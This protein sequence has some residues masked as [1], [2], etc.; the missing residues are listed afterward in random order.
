M[1][2]CMIKL[3]LSWRTYKIQVLKI[4]LLNYSAFVS[5]THLL[6]PY[7]VMSNLYCPTVAE[8]GNLIQIFVVDQSIYRNLTG[9][10]SRFMKTNLNVKSC[11]HTGDCECVYL[12]DGIP[13]SLKPCRLASMMLG[14]NMFSNEDFLVLSGLCRCF[15]IV[16]DNTKLTFAIDNYKSIL[17]SDMYNQ[18]CSVID[19]ELRNGRVT[20]L[21]KPAACIHAL[22]AVVRPN[23]KLTSP[24]C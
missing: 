12:L 17:D 16:D 6:I 20:C 5:L 9:S 18:M 3:L 2:T 4:I 1:I 24:V 15:R 8:I 21:S 10:L 14:R 22:G 23:G 7:K 13:A 19:T 11:C